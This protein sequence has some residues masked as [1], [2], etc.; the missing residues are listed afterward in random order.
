M[1]G[2]E[3]SKPTNF[4]NGPIKSHEFR[5]RHVLIYKQLTNQSNQLA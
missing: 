4:T 5:G 3:N 2:S 1:R